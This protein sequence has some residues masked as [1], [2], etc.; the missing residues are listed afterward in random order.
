[1]NGVAIGG[2]TSA[3]LTINPANFAQLGNYSVSVSNPAGT[4]TSSNAKLS[5]TSATAY[6]PGDLQLIF[7][8]TGFND[9][10]FNLGSVSNYLNLAVNSTV[11]VPVN[12][13]IVYTNFANSLTSVKFAVAAANSAKLWLSDANLS[14]IPSDV[15]LSKFSALR[16]KV[17][18]AGVQAAAITAGVNSL[19]IAP[20]AVSAWDAIVSPGNSGAVGTLGGDSV[21][22]VEAVNSNSVAFYQIL[23]SATTPKPLA[24]KIGTFAY[25]TDGTVT[26]TAASVTPVLLTST[27]P[28]QTIAAGASSSTL[29]VTASDASNYQ[30]RLNGSAIANA[31]NASF[32]LTSAT[33]ADAGNY[34][35][36]VSNATYGTTVTSGN[37]VITVVGAPTIVT[38]P[39]SLTI[40][41]GVDATFTITATND[42]AG[43]GSNP[44]LAY[45]WLF[46]GSVITDATNASYTIV[47]AQFA[48]GG[49][50]S[51][52]AS[53]FA[54]TATSSNAA[55]VVIDPYISVQPVS[56][57]VV[58][59]ATAT[60]SV[61]A[62]GTAPMT[63]QWK[64]SGTNVTGGT[65]AT[66]T[67]PN[68]STNFNGRV[69]SVVVANANGTA[70]SSNATLSVGANVVFVTQPASLTK[71]QGQV[72]SFTS[73]AT[74]LA[75]LTYQWQLNGANIVG[76]NSAGY[77][78]YSVNTNDA[79]NYTVI[80][81]NNIGSVT[82]AV[83]VL[84]VNLDTI[85]PTVVITAPAAG[86]TLFVGNTNLIGTAADMNGRVSQVQVS[87]NGG[88]FT[89][90][91]LNI[92]NLSPAAAS[93]SYALNFAVGTNTV[94]V[95]SV[96]FAGNVS[97]T[98]SR[99]SFYAVPSAL[100]VNVTG[101]GFVNSSNQVVS[102]GGS[103]LYVGRRYTL[104][105]I[106]TNTNWLFSNWV[107][108][109]TSEIS[110]SNIYTFLMSS[111]LVLNVNFVTNRF[112]A[113]AGSYYGLFSETNGAA[114][115]SA[116]YFTVKTDRKQAF[117]GTVFVDG[118]STAIAGKF[119]LA[120]VGY[121]TKPILR[122]GKATL[123]VSLQLNF[124]DSI[125]GTVSC[126]GEDWTAPLS[127][128][129][130]VFSATNPATNLFAPKYTLLIPGSTN[131]ATE[132]A[133]YGYAGLTIKPDGTVATTT[134]SATLA[135]GQAIT[136]LKATVSKHGD[137]PF[138]SAQYKVAFN[139]GSNFI[140]SYN[141]A[142]IGWLHFETN[143][144]ITGTLH[145][146]KT[147]WTNGYYDAGFNISSDA[148]GSAYD[149]PAT[150]ARGIFITN[151]VTTISDGNLSAPFSLNVTISNNN[152]F[153]FAANTIGATAKLASALNGIVSGTFTNSTTGLKTT[154]K[155]V[156]LPEQNII[157]AQF[158][159]TNQTGGVL[160]Q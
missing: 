73:R 31:T 109:A 148:Q 157:G 126:A 129:R 2:A 146:I 45:Q 16:G 131:V 13:N 21:F 117:S 64:F 159:G 92:T 140:T 48:N 82:S 97:T 39:T 96:D 138:Y 101:E 54:G 22:A 119:D 98:V 19:I 87:L 132:P 88:A 84:T 3:S 56:T 110:S 127:G 14:T 152:A 154:F 116:G 81:A 8:K 114:E 7:R 34:S 27:L 111:N 153:A 25:N 44:T 29:A 103:N 160:I 104:T 122:K 74:G 42:F 36:V 123:V 59:G 143:S 18:N 40:N 139:T 12:T 4:V 106:P 24:Q 95:K 151:G 47:N 17:D 128:D 33:T 80:A 135:D 9:V 57:G 89:D 46:N 49:N 79:G 37:A 78:N 120:G 141:G 150:G 137:W 60:F 115:H 156:Y 20:T 91:T 93:W 35:V 75:P 69:Y 149:A 113:A 1:F 133:G 142:L 55:L 118:D 38:Q 51:C 136:S 90:A 62:V 158:L 71:N 43:A 83:A 107:N 28:A 23:P 67:I 85:A 130:N 30:W 5:F 155:G 94:A 86:A 125:G 10:E 6:L 112:I 63:Y 32:T 72:A 76:A 68:C 102:L 108:T 50:Y 99:T 124:D 26:F 134:A 53:N 65:N 61:T 58:A 41:N 15:T 100:A 144:T 147:S 121:T 105:A 52:V 77:T 145:W 11:S 66:L 70:T